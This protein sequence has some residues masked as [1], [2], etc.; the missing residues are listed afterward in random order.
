VLMMQVVT[1]A[2]RIVNQHPSAPVLPALC[3]RMPHVKRRVSRGP[4]TPASRRAQIGAPLAA[5]GAASK[6]MVVA[7]RPMPCFERALR[8]CGGS[9]RAQFGLVCH[10]L[11]KVCCA[12]QRAICGRAAAGERECM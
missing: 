6:Q 5:Q 3:P 12:A 7:Q 4:A 8:S 10:A 2:C 11:P 1:P 9:G